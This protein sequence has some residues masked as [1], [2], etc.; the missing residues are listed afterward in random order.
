[1]GR[2]MR[3]G[4]LFEN[5]YRIIAWSLGAGR[6]PSPLPLLNPFDKCQKPSDTG[7]V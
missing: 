3:L 1:M 6:F 4:N 5:S 7:I 2:M